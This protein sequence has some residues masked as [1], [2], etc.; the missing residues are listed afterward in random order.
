[1]SINPSTQ[2]EIKNSDERI[3]FTVTISSSSSMSELFIIQ[4]INNSM[5]DTLLS[6]NITGTDIQEQFSYT[7]PNIPENDTSI[8]KLLFYCKDV[9][10]RSEQ[11]AKV[12]SVISSDILLNETTGH[13]M[14][15]A[16]STK[17]NAYN[18]LNGL[19]MYSSDSTSH[20]NDNTD[21]LSNIL[22]RE[23]VSSSGLLFAKFNNFDYA[24]ATSQTIKEAYEISLKK[25]FTDNISVDDIIITMIMNKYI[26]IKLIYVI[27]DIGSEDDKYIFSIKQ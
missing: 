26:V 3:D 27:D 20:I 16:N 13:T 23:W 19:P 10:E 22:S 11:R 12:F 17:Y 18:L 6:K 15:S 14:Y 5:V 25:E 2:N 9:N 8:I 4:T 1:M 7:T 21:S 24:N